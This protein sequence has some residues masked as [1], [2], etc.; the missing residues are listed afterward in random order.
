MKNPI[1]ITGVGGQVGGIGLKIVKNLVDRNLPVRALIHQPDTAL[2]NEL[3]SQGVEVV[4]GD[5]TNLQDVHHAI[6]D[7]KR[8]YF[9]MGI[10]DK[11]LEA[12][13]NM[14]AV[15]KHYKIECLVNISQMTVSYMSINETTS[16]PQQKLH[17]LCEQV[18]NWSLLP[19]VHVRSTVFLEHPFFSQ[20]AAK[21]ISES[22][23]IC[24][25]FGSAKT[26]PIATVDVARVISVILSEPENHV[27]MVYELTGP[28]SETIYEIAEEYSAALGRKITYVDIPLERWKENL[29]QSGMPAHLLSHII[30]MA[31]LHRQNRYDRM[32]T[33]VL[34]V[35]GIPPMSV[36]HWVKMNSNLFERKDDI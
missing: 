18:L 25:P 5:L 29:L 22:G 31:E 23:E 12:T 24:L 32:T 30:T 20:W 1:L 26:S 9:G 6:K 8:L 36:Q 27:G 33:D 16:S 2:E 15:A 11:Y 7:C 28:K 35:T 34:Q 19:V 14:A 21:S 13:V 10:S 4:F 3:K 17:W